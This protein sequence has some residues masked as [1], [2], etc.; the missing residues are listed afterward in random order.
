MLIAAGDMRRLFE[1]LRLGSLED[2]IFD[3]AMGLVEHLAHE[4]GHALSLGLVIGPGIDKAIALT[5]S[6]RS[7]PVQIR[8][9][10]LVLAAECVALP[11]L[12]VHFDEHTPG[13][14]MR[15]AGEV[16]GVPDKVFWR[17][18]GSRAARELGMRVLHY[19]LRRSGR[20]RRS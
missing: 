12:G 17:A 6:D 18:F 8:E 2:P 9:E 4:I 3:G 19:L 15:D 16:Q 20:G 1:H 11:R 7:K 14:T 10:A 13:L 5:L